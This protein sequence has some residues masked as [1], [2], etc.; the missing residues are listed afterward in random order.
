MLVDV[1]YLGNDI[2]NARVRCSTD[3]CEVRMELKT[4]TED[5]IKKLKQLAVKKYNEVANLTLT[6]GFTREEIFKTGNIV[7]LRSGAKYEIV[8][9]EY[10]NASLGNTKPQKYKIALSITSEVAYEVVCS[11][12]NDYGFYGTSAFMDIVRVYDKNNNLKA[13]R[14]TLNPFT[15]QKLTLDEGEF[16]SKGCPHKKRIGILDK[17]KVLNRWNKKK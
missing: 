10:L 14:S 1:N 6:K 9:T 3:D 17:D 12:W 7:E 13:E 16:W 2:Y 4:Y 8:E 11:Q 5:E 15:T